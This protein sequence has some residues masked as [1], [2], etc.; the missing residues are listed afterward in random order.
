MLDAD[1]YGRPRTCSNAV[2]GCRRPH[3]R[4]AS[5][6]PR[7]PPGG[8]C[9][10]LPSNVKVL[11]RRRMGS[12]RKSRASTCRMRSSTARRSARASDAWFRG[13]LRDMAFDLLTGPSRLFVG[14]TFDQAAVRQSFSARTSAEI[15]TSSRGSGRCCR[16]EVMASRTHSAAA[17]SGSPSRITTPSAESDEVGRCES[18]P[19][20]PS[21]PVDESGQQRA[22][23]RVGQAEVGGDL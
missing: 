22:R 14:T 8:A 9:V 7:S 1:A 6:S 23:L 4:A 21:E 10:S 15:A 12:S 13:G 20:S 16:W 2:T 11:I 19:T 5:T 3:R 17:R 18:S